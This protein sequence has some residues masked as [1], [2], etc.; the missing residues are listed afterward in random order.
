MHTFFNHTINFS[1]K[2][3]VF[4]I[5]ISLQIGKCTCLHAYPHH[6]PPIDFAPSNRLPH[7]DFVLAARQVNNK[8]TE[9]IFQVLTEL[10]LNDYNDKN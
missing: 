2:L 5:L 7:F 3:Y 6:T 10:H 4:V 9:S 1:N 8:L